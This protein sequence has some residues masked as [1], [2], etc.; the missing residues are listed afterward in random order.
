MKEILKTGLKD[1]LLLM[2]LFGAGEAGLRLFYPQAAKHV[3]TDTISG[4]HRIVLNPYGLRDVDFPSLRPEGE[5]RVLCIGDS[6]TFGAGVDADETYPKQLER[7]L[8]ERQ[9]NNRWRV[10]NGGGQGASV[11]GLTEF[12]REK[13]LGFGPETVVLAFSPTM[14]SVA[15]QSEN[16]AGPPVKQTF[17]RW[18]H[19]ELLAVHTRLNGTYLY[20]FVDA[21]VRRR[22][23]R[24]GVLRDRMDHPQGALVAYAFDVPGVEKGEVDQ[25]YSVFEREL[26]ELKKTLEENRV[27]LVVLGIPSRFRVS[28]QPEDNERG[29]D[30][31]KI[32]IEP[33]ERVGAACARLGIRFVDLQPRLA[34][35]RAAMKERRRA[36]DELYVETDY[37]H[38]NSTGMRTA[39]EELRR[40]L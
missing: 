13:G 36:R 39:A 2:L 21:S 9:E 25:A 27:R 31:T 26:T 33:M 5:R 10:I 19:G 11:T 22:L 35:E 23:Y 20:P 14:I 38:L 8:N 17:A 12:M 18:F 34:A 6:T 3:F 24:W 29:Y 37:A 15:G 7:M 4:G 40:L 28:P 30:L 1:L 16:S 32:R